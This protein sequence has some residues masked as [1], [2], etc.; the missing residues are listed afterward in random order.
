MDP[1]HRFVYGRPVRGAEFVSREQELRTLFN[2][3]YNGESAA[4]SGM[5][6]I[7]KSSLLLKIEDPATQKAYL[8]EEM[9]SNLYC[10]YLNL[11]GIRSDYAV[12][13]FWEEALEPLE[14]SEHPDVVR[15]WEQAR[16]GRYGQRHLTRLFDTLGRHHLRLLLLLDEFDQLFHQN[17]FQIGEFFGN[18]RTVIST[19]ALALVL[20]SRMKIADMNR[21]ADGFQGAAGSPFFNTLIDV[22]LR[23]F[24]HESV[25]QLQRDVPPALHRFTTQ[26]AGTHPYLLQGILATLA[27]HEYNPD[28]ANLAAVAD[29]FYSRVSHVFKDWWKA[30]DNGTR[31]LVIRLSQI[32]LGEPAR[33]EEWAAPDLVSKLREMQGHGLARMLDKEEVYP[34]HLDLWDNGRWVI[35]CQALAWWV[36][37]QAISERDKTLTHQERFV[38]NRLIDERVWRALLSEMRQHQQQEIDRIDL[39]QH[40]VE[41]MDKDNIQTLCFNLSINYDNLSGDTLNT[42]VQALLNYTHQRN[43]LLALV[44]TCANLRPDFDWYAAV[45]R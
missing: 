14:E 11:Q 40:M 22:W 31:N 32:E 7:G 36:R 39:Y 28:P 2:R 34:L 13:N 45:V 37:E 33:P 43:M 44:Q 19:G 24:D 29:E 3:I 25:K 41:K 26:I 42:K 17:G 1:L 5:P 30:I 27:E 4:V 20:S 15:R 38:D 18:L 16:D 35:G 9:A 10:S 8:G 21:E 23:P 6:R 12:V